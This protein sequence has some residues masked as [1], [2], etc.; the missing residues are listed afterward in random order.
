MPL[1][2]YVQQL[3]T[4][5]EFDTNHVDRIQDLLV[6]ETSV[7]TSTVFIR[8][9]SRPPL[10]GTSLLAPSHMHVMHGDEIRRP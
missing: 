5:E 4:R 8:G 3:R 2:R 6:S 7:V 1:Q 9:T 10:P